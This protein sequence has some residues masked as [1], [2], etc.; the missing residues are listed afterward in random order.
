MPY[1]FFQLDSSAQSRHD[2]TCERNLTEML[3][4]EWERDIEAGT[5]ILHQRAFTEKLLKSFG[6]WQYSKPTKTPQPPGT[7]LSAADKPA[8]PDPVMHRRYRSIV[9]AMDSLNHR[10]KPD[11]NHAYFELSKFVQSPGQKH[12]D[13]AEY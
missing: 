6:F 4:M 9:G 11:I 13:A 8:T 7:R 12:M 10:T 1:S 5:S 2:G 3:S